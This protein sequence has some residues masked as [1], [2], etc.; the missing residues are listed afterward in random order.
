MQ[1]KVKKR[2]TIE[3]FGGI[4]AVWLILEDCLGS[5]DFADLAT[6]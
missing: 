3:A 1:L 5:F 6:P 4:F 2:Q